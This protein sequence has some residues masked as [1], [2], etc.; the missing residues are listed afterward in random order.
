MATLFLQW[1]HNKRAWMTSLIFKIWMEK[2]NNQ[3][4]LVQRNILMFVDNCPAHPDLNL[5]NV[6]LVFLPPNTTSKLQPCDAGII[7]AVKMQYRKRLLRHIIMEM[8]GDETAT[9]PMIAK[10]VTVLDAVLW[11]KSS[12]DALVPTTIEKCFKKCGFQDDS[13]GKLSQ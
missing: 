2:L 1:E 13:Q 11:L 3:M 10:S 9:A 6:R 4:R 12:W 5:S 7:Q 8:D